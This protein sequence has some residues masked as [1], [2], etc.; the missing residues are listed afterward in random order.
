MIKLL[1]FE[2]EISQIV[3]TPLEFCKKQLFKFVFQ[4]SA[5]MVGWYAGFDPPPPL[6]GQPAQQVS[7]RK[8]SMGRDVGSLA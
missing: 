1:V 3:S 2:F 7:L 5:D 4:N 8:P 6:M